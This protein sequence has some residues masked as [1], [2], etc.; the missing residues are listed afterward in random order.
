MKTT[1]YKVYVKNIENIMKT[2]ILFLAIVLFGVLAVGC[3]DEPPATDTP[4][5]TT[6]VQP[7]NEIH[8]ISDSIIKINLA[9]Y[10]IDSNSIE[11]GCIIRNIPLEE[12]VVINTQQEYERIF[13]GCA[14]SMN[15]DFSSCSLIVIG[16]GCDGHVINKEV[17]ATQGEN[18]ISITVNIQGDLSL[19]PSAWAVALLCGKIEDNQSI[20]LTVNHI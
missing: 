12:A 5:D 9:E 4:Q 6:S 1:M 16:G 17:V 18:A 8:C 11:N 20:T 2:R 3:E 15:I 7:R 13:S 10:G 19:E 14:G